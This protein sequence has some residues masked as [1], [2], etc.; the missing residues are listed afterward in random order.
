MVC[1]V[2]ISCISSGGSKSVAQGLDTSDIQQDQAGTVS[3]GTS[4]NTENVT[5]SDVKQDQGGTV[6]QLIPSNKENVT[7]GDVKLN[8]GSVATQI[9]PE[10]TQNVIDCSE[11]KYLHGLRAG[12]CL[13]TIKNDK[14]TGGN[15]ND[16]II[17]AGGDDYIVGDR[18][19]DSLYGSVGDD[20]I[21]G[22]QGNDLIAGNEGEDKL[23]G[24][25]GDDVIFA[26]QDQAP[27]PYRTNETEWPSSKDI[28]DCGSGNDTV[29][30][31]PLD[32][33]KNCENGNPLDTQS[34]TSTETFKNSTKGLLL[35]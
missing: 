25:A 17:G 18:G 35:P 31:D 23:S 21:I 29:Y 28:V 15:L 26:G 10:I 5:S 16:R 14:M 22:Q 8:Q 13:G 32:S 19:N 2:L 12:D 33:Y 11:S 30:V 24:G 20:H 4:S 7:S 9:T 6:S 1:F 3:Q 34:V 27:N